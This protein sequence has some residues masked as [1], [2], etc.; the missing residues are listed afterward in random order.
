MYRDITP[1]VQALMSQA[2][3]LV[4]THSFVDGYQASNEKCVGLVLSK[5]LQWDSSIITACK[6][7]LQDAN[8]SQVADAL[9]PFD[10]QYNGQNEEE[11][12]Q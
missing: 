7:A 9:D 12:T 2:V 8:F 5:Y 4:R 6:E 11:R 10:R 1:E 3:E